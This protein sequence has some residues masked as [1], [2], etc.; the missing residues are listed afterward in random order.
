MGIT[1]AEPRSSDSAGIDSGKETHQ[2]MEHAEVSSTPITEVDPNAGKL[3]KDVILAYL[4]SS[5]H[6]PIAFSEGSR[7]CRSTEY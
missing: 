1:T 2:E 6:L 4:V 7:T 3:T 5:L